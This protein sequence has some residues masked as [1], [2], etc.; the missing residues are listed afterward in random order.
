MARDGT[1]SGENYVF[2]V[3]GNDGNGLSVE[4]KTTV[5]SVS[6]WDGPS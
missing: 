2:I 5:D 3:V 4:T 6:A 1:G